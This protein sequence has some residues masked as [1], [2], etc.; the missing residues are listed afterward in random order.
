MIN[1][2]LAQMRNSEKFFKTDEVIHIINGR[3]KQQLGFFV[4]EK[5]REEFKPFLQ[6]IEDD[7]NMNALKLAA[8]AQAMDP[9][10]DSTIGDGI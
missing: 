2:T 4:P 8:E 10:G 1:A 7:K 9:I 6:K 5:L 3:K